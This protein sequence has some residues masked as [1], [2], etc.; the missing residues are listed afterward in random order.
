MLMVRPEEFVVH[1]SA[2]GQEAH[3]GPKLGQPA[4]VATPADRRYLPGRT[5]DRPGIEVDT[6]IVFRVAAVPAVGGGHL[7]HHLEPLV[8]QVG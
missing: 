8:F 6:E 7:G 3:A 4:A 5:G 1:C 2:S